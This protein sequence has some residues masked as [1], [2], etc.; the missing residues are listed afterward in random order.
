MNQVARRTLAR[1]P[2][3]VAGTQLRLALALLALVLPLSLAAAGTGV[4]PGDV[5]VTRLVQGATGGELA[6]VVAAVNAFGSAPVIT[7]VTLGAALAF[8]AA[9]QRSAALMV[10]ATLPIHGLNATL[11]SIAE[12]PR[13]TSDLVRV[14][15]HADSFG[16]P[17]GHVMTTTLLCGVLLY[18][19]TTR[20]RHHVARRAIQAVALALPLA[21]G[22]ARIATG[23]HWPSD[24]LGGY[25]WG[26]L[27]VLAVVAASRAAAAGTSATARALGRFVPGSPR[28]IVV[29]AASP[30]V[31]ARQSAVAGSGRGGV[32]SGTPSTLSLGSHSSQRG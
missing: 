30:R 17:S 14:T 31:A 11:K 5:A 18:L 10:V 1:V 19:A 24:V 3:A 22:I 7:A 21:M 27:V 15:E 23:A 8:L 26:A 13:P 29:A 2:G 12:S 4:L 20:V 28:P 9:R 16:F 32:S 6:G 25:L